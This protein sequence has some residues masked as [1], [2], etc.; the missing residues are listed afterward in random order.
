M[1]A[2]VIIS[3]FSWFTW[4]NEPIIRTYLSQGSCISAYSEGNRN[5]IIFLNNPYYS[6]FIISRYQIVLQLKSSLLYILF[7]TE[8][9][10]VCLFEESEHFVYSDGWARNKNYTGQ[11]KPVLRWPPG[12]V[13][14]LK[15]KKGSVFERDNDATWA[16]K[17]ERWFKTWK[18][19][20]FF[21]QLQ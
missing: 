19:P 6:L 13:W 17:G 1:K 16:R 15:I 14:E 10:L 9:P 8:Q 20:V 12:E 3:I 21:E 2:F 7:G 4:K 18:V 11:Q 5:T